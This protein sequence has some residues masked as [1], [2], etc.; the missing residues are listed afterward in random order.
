MIVEENIGLVHSIVRRFAQRGYEA[1]DLFQIGCI[2]LVKAIQKFDTSFDVKFSTY[3]VPMIMGEIKRFIRDDGIIKVSRS[4]KELGI[5]AL[6]LRESIIKETNKEP[7]IK[8]LSEKLGAGLEDVAM[9]LEAGIRPESINASVVDND[10]DGKTL[11]ERLESKDDCESTV[12]NKV[13]IQNLLQMFDDREK[14]IIIL[15]YFKQKTQ[16]EIAKV[17]GISQVQ[18]S[19]IEKKVLTAM[20]E[21]LLE[22]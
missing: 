2:G 1:E 6:M 14:K 13:L 22:K 18:V 16:S 17:M 9:A 5:K 7:T 3:A 15:R 10:G 4:I 21:K 19:R 20:R 11:G 12:I 8:E